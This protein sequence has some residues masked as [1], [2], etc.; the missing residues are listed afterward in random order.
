MDLFDSFLG[1]L[2]YTY[3]INLN[4]MDGYSPYKVTLSIF[5][6]L[7]NY[8]YSNLD[9]RDPTLKKGVTSIIT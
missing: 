6:L 2:T 8:H 3:H 4:G 1:Q 5:Y 7:N 9:E